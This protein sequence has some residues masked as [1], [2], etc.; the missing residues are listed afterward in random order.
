MKT[1]VCVFINIQIII[2]NFKQNQFRKTNSKDFRT[3][4]VEPF[5]FQQETLLPFLCFIQI[6]SFHEFERVV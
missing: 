4:S 2:Y 1:N 6:N 3:D 5:Q